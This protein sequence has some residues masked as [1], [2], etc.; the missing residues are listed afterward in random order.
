MDKIS[1]YLTKI[2]RKDYL[3]SLTKIKRVGMKFPIIGYFDQM[4]KRKCSKMLYREIENEGMRLVDTKKRIIENE[5]RFTFVK[6]NSVYFLFL[7]SIIATCLI[8]I[9]YVDNECNNLLKTTTYLE[10]IQEKSTSILM[11]MT[12]AATSSVWK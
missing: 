8:H 12:D 7:L 11:T 6:N 2:D 1:T 9:Q 5:S 10:Q 4:H 3:I